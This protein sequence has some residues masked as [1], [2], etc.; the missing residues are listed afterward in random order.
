MQGL[1][2]NVSEVTAIAALVLNVVVA[3]VGLTW[4]LGKIRDTVRDEIEEHRIAFDADIDGLRREFGETAIVFRIDDGPA[5]CGHHFVEL[6]L[7]IALISLLRRARAPYQLRDDCFC[8]AGSR[9]GFCG[10]G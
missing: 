1:P 2:V 8:G 9:Y 6:Q 7:G 5:G 10:H 4:G 3:I